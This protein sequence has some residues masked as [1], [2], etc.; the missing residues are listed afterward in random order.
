MNK[1][2][3]GF[4][5]LLM[6]LET[7]AQEGLLNRQKEKLKEKVSNRTENRIDRGVDKTLD[8]AEETVFDGNKKEKKSSKNKQNDTPDNNSGEETEAEAAVPGTQSPDSRP[9]FKAYSKYD[10]VP[11]DNVLAVDNFSTTNPGDFPANWNTNASAEI[12]TLEGMEE[13]F[14]KL[15]H[16]GVFIPEGFQKLPANFTLEFDLVTT[17][18]FSEMQDGLK[19]HLVKEQEAPLLFDPFF[20]PAPQISMDIH[21][22]VEMTFNHIWVVHENEKKV[23]DNE[24]RSKEIT[25]GL[26]HVAI[27]RQNGR[28][29]LYLNEHKIWDL[30]KAFLDQVGYELILSTYTWEGDLFV[31]NFRLAEGAPDTRNKLLQQGKFVTNGI[32]FDT[33]SDKIKPE[34]Y[35]I[36]KEIADALKQDP[37]IRVRIEGYTDSDGD[38]ASNLVLSQKR[39]DAVKKMLSAEFGI[40]AS[41]MET[42]GKG[43]ADPVDSNQTDAGKANNRRV[44][45]IRL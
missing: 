27:W 2:W 16:N 6:S 36:I 1:I 14:L 41:R 10:F 8:K 11:G 35:G 30:P 29:R 32:R 33:N 15:S 22:A 23:L 21:P 45:F 17:P 4:A 5:V 31:G 18:D 19:V 43:E 25:N 26:I 20:N 7:T 13:K 9:D 28:M 3:I 40:D 44:A 39:A 24:N 38:E 12:V 42:L 34:S 37:A